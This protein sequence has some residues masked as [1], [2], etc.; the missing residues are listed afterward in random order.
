MSETNTNLSFII[1][2]AGIPYFC[3]LI[4]CYFICVKNFQEFNAILRKDSYIYTKM[5]VAVS[6]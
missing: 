2:I 1:S 4:S 6:R 3:L 5:I